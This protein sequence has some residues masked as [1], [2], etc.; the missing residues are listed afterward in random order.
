MSVELMPWKKSVGM[1]A[2]PTLDVEKQEVPATLLGG[3]S[4]AEPAV[5]RTEEQKMM[6][7]GFTSQV[8]KLTKGEWA[9]LEE[10][11]FTK[12]EWK[13]YFALRGMEQKQAFGRKRFPRVVVP[14]E[15]F[16]HEL[17]TE[18]RIRWGE[19][20]VREYAF[21]GTSLKNGGNGDKVFCDPVCAGGENQGVFGTALRLM[22]ADQVEVLR[23]LPLVVTGDY[24]DETFQRALRLKEEENRIIADA[25]EIALQTVKES[26]SSSDSV[27]YVKSVKRT[28]EADLLSLRE[29]LLDGADVHDEILF[30]EALLEAL[31]M[32]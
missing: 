8:I 1:P 7:A 20:Q 12:E 24:C 15:K 6:T 4:S 31:R 25:K 17:A 14:S 26:Q 32:F 13:A 18:G 28:A 3:G 5:P 9:I 19:N 27:A 22:P 2:G 16:P 30:V 29:K 23:H 10:E 11:D 21:T